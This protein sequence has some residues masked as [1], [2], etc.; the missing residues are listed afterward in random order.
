MEY[1]VVY[2]PRIN[3]QL[4]LQLSPRSQKQPILANMHYQSTLSVLLLLAT[5]ISAQTRCDPVASAIPTC[6]VSPQCPPL[7]A[8][9]TDI[10]CRSRASNPPRLPLVV[11]E[12]IMRADALTLLPFKTVRL[13]V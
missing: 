8:F 2:K 3:T 10:S 5:S 4:Q 13:G 6:G 12:L 1:K 9:R 7:L 11:A